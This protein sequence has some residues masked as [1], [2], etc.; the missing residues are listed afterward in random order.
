MFKQ[1]IV[2]WQVEQAVAR[3]RCVRAALACCTRLRDIDTTMSDISAGA[4]ATATSTSSSA[5]AT[6][7]AAPKVGK[8]GKKICCACP[9]T[10]KV[11]DACV[12]MKGE[13]LCTAEIDAHKVCLRADG[14]DVQ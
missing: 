13:A 2:N 11:R 8:S 3:A 7:A 6:S 12:V 4:A 14:F 1:C 10:R 5:A 9:D